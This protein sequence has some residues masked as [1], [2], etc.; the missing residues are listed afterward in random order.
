MSLQ[1]FLS[2]LGLDE[3]S[4]KVYLALLQSGDAPATVISKRAGIKRTTTHHHLESLIGLGLASS[5]RQQNV[6]RF[7]AENPSKI[8][9]LLEAKIAM[10]EKSLPELQ[11]VSVIKE[12]FTK[13]RLF[14]GEEGIGQ[15]VEEELASQEKIVRSIGSMK[16]LRKAANGKITFTS[17]RLEKKIFSRC[18][19]PENDEFK[20]G[21]LE[22]QQQDLREVRLLPKDSDYPGMTFIYDDKVAVITPDEE[23]IGFIIT[24]KTFSQGIKTTFDLLWEISKKTL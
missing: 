14:E 21:W 10:F 13:L 15:I 19:R 4:Q 7:V 11:K 8:K 6:K 22:K 1:K 5:Y 24:S 9:G 17:R 18:L 20:K 23:G 3:K 2:S 12:R 16:D